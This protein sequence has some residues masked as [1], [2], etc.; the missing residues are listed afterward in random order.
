MYRI[1]VIPG[2]GIGPEVMEAALLVLE[3]MGLDMEFFSAM[4]G[5]ACFQKLGTTIPSQTID[6][7]LQSDATLF[8]AVTTVPGQKSAILTHQ[9][10][11]GCSRACI[12]TEEGFTMVGRQILH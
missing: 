10:C 1:C 5:N 2:D 4:A 12:N 11:L 3:A 6:L 7:A 9:C 8:G